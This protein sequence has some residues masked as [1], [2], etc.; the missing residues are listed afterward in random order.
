MRV[1]VCVFMCDDGIV[2]VCASSF[3]IMG[4]FRHACL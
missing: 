4:L 3:I 1:V 2:C